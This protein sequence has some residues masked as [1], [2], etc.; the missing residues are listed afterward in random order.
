MTNVHKWLK[1]APQSFAEWFKNNPA[2]DLLALAK[3]YGGLGNVPSGVMDTFEAERAEWELR[4][5]SRHL[6][7]ETESSSEPPYHEESEPGAD[8]PTEIM[9]KIE[10]NC[11]RRCLKKEK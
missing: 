2:P 3:H 10:A 1:P 7:P 4:R 11:R 6:D 9:A 5:K 8:I